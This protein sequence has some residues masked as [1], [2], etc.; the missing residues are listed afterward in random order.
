MTV[1]DT[2]FYQE[3]IQQCPD[4]K[5]NYWGLGLSYLLRGETESAFEIWM[6]SLL[7]LGLFANEDLTQ[8]LVSFLI[9]NIYEKIKEEDWENV[10]IIYDAISELVSEGKDSNSDFDALETEINQKIEILFQSAIIDSLSQK[11]EQAEKHY[12]QVLILNPSHL[13]AWGNLGMIYYETK[14]YQEAHQALV[15]T[16]TFDDSIARYHFNL[17]M[18]LEKLGQFEMAKLAYQ[19]V[20]QLDALFFDAYNAL[21]VI[22]KNQGHYQ[23]AISLLE[24]A[25]D[26]HPDYFNFYLNLGNVYF[27][28]NN[29]LKAIEIYK[30]SFYINP[31]SSD[32]L[33]NLG[34]CYEE[35]NEKDK[36]N[37]YYGYSEYKK[38]SFIEATKIL[39]RINV[40][41]LEPKNGYF[42]FMLADCYS[43]VS[44]IQDAIVLCEQGI[45]LF[46]EYVE[47]YRYLFSLY[48]R[49]GKIEEAKALTQRAII[50]FPQNNDFQR[51]AQV[52]LPVIY[53][54]LGEILSYRRCFITS[55]EQLIENTKIDS[56]EDRINALQGINLTTNYYLHYQNFNDLDV[57]KKYGDL[58]YRIMSASFPQWDHPLIMPPV[59]DKIRI[60][61][62]SQRFHKGFSCLLLGWYRNLN[63]EKFEIYT[64]DLE[65]PDV[66]DTPEYKILS[67]AYYSFSYRLEDACQQILQDKLHI[68]IYVDIGLDTAITQMASRKLAPIQCVTWGHPITSGLSTIDFFLGSDAMEPPNAQDHYSEILIR[69]NKLGFCLSE[70]P[71]QSSKP[72]T[73]TRSDLGFTEQDILYFCCQH[74]Q[75]YLPQYDYLLAEIAMRIDH[76][77]FIFIEG[78]QSSEVSQKLITR[79]G[80]VFQSYELNPDHYLCLIKCLNI[81]SYFNFLRNVDVF[82]D[83][84][85]WSG[86]LTTIDAIA[87]NL[88][89]VTL[90]GEFMRGRQSTGMLEIIGVTDTIAKDEQDYINIAVKLGLDQ[91]YKKSIIEKMQKNQHLL[92][93]DQQCIVDLENFIQSAVQQYPNQN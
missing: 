92:F 4:N 44:R 33:F 12:Q 30:K 15:R 65:R 73:Q 50:R 23:E 59:E 76:A 29:F 81:E 82:L 60:G 40:V 74:I 35:L 43:C 53:D 8:S 22:E 75:K 24:K 48:E 11:F 69:L 68:L 5:E 28:Q 57:Q 42:H 46:P 14:R 66:V 51:L 49:L 61:F 10:K 85:G 83:T 72:I 18:I 93:D 91:E 27:A 21:A 70:T 13:Q 38:G 2:Y 19:T 34:K 56:E 25:I 16:L 31:E 67:Y 71:L 88:P 63:Q 62:V 90:P 55:L 79:I 77:K 45:S 36:A 84:I 78:Y 86:G 54:S 17:G 89:I 3:A 1:Q 64:Y 41:K 39:E 52:L 32:I 6:S 47:L 58:V 37:F 87:C 7:D 26:L 9:E 20:I 80:Q